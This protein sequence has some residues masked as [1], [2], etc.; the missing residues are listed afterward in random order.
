MSLLNRLVWIFTAP[1][2]VFDDVREGRASWWEPWIWQSIL[3][4]IAAWLSLPIQRRIAELNPRG[5]SPDQLEKQAQAMAKFAWLQIVATP[6]MILVFG[7]ALAGVTY[8]VVTILSSRA[9]FRQYFTITLYSSIIGGLSMVVSNLV[10][11]MRGVETIRTAQDAQVTF[12]LGFLA[13]EGHSVVAAMLSTVNVFSIWGFVILGLGLM[14]VFGMTRNQAIACV[15]PWWLIS[16]A[17]A[18]GGAAFSGL[19]GAP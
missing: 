4:M 9:N 7:L 19:G 16:L 8:I 5:L 17:L 15:I 2:R 13:P 3:Y 18:A 14:R 6:P 11:R 1:T 10:V 12:G